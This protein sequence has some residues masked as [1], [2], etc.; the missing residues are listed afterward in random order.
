VSQPSPSVQ[1][2]G[3]A[4]T[5]LG[6][7]AAANAGVLVPPIG[8]AALGGGAGYLLSDFLSATVRTAANLTG[9]AAVAGGVITKGVVGTG[10]LGLGWKMTR[11]GALG[12]I[13]FFT[14]GAGAFISGVIDVVR[15]FWDVEAWGKD[16]GNKIRSWLN[17]APVAVQTSN[18]MT[19]RE[20]EEQLAAQRGNNN[21]GNRG[22][23]TI[24]L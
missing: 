22:G 4:L 20:Y 14:A 7:A 1:A 12:R 16:F 3:S 23:V 2:L 9:K 5:Q 10:L 13:G 21:P 8:A 15:Y 17:M 18:R 19:R 24:K 6:T 11:L